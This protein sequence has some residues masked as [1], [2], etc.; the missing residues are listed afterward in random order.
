M[1]VVPDKRTVLVRSK[2]PMLIREV[3]PNSKIGEFPEGHNVAIKYGLEEVQV[4]RNLN[5]KVPSPIEHYYPWP[6]PLTPFQHQKETASFLSVNNKAFV[7][8]EMGTGKSASVLWAA[9]YLLEQ[10]LVKKVL[11]VSPLSTLER[12]WADEINRILMH[13]NCVVLHGS[14]QRRLDKL[15]QDADFYIIN[16][17]GLEVIWKDLAKRKDIDLIVV[18]EASVY[19]NAS[20]KRYKTLKTMLSPHHKLWLLTGTPCPN[21]PTDAWALAKLVNPAK[22]PEFFGRWQRMTMYQVSE[23]KWAPKPESYDLAF[24]AMQPA[25]RFRKEDCLDLPPVVFE[26]REVKMTSSQSSA[27]QEMKDDFVAEIT[28]A[29]G[30]SAI[31]AVNA[32]DKLNKIRQIMCG[33]VKDTSTGEYIELDHAPRASVLLECIEEASA[34]CIVVV[35]FKGIINTLYE[36]VKKHHSCAILNG[37]VPVAKRNAIL[38]EFKNSKDPHVLL[39]HPKVMSHGLNLTEADMI[40][41][42][43]PIYSNDEYQQVKDRINRPGQKRKM[44][45][46]RLGSHALEWKI[47]E[48]LDSKAL[49]QEGI[50]ELFKQEMG[51]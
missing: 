39:C 26:D 3:I 6:G 25:I 12:V 13:R 29:G 18:D 38:S 17:D 47:Y 35:P 43:A 49:T 32:A 7:F 1:I 27:Y 36:K 16:H 50:L 51:A 4:L 40:V 11:I 20:T 15:A 14:K 19:R 9:D 41:F 10:K 21:A 23:Y 44:T 45:I 30:I 22:V 2:N 37:D 8:N 28:S 5:I 48:R 24:Q 31:S 34:K 42:Y 46:V 33:V